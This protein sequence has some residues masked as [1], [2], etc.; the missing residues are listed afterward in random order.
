MTTSETE[1][2]ARVIVET[3]RTA[4]TP[5]I[6]ALGQYH[7]VTTPNG[8]QTID[9]T[10]DAYRQTPARK[11]GTT[12]VADV[13]SFAAYWAK[14]RD[15][16]SDLYA[17]RASRTVTAVLDAHSAEAARWGQHR[18]VLR[19][20]HSEAWNA[21]ISRDNRPMQ[22]E[23][24]AEHLEDNRADIFAPSAAEML[25]I[26][27]SIQG[28]AKA[29]F[30]SGT[31]LANGARKLAYVE[32]VSAT[33]GERGDLI[34]PADFTLRLGVFEGATHG[35]DVLARFRYRINGGKLSLTYKLERPADV[36]A[37]AF[38]GVVAEVGEAC[39]ATVLRG[40]APS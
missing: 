16:G 13:D 23:E 40:T 9:L 3:A 21:W 33:A 1:T 4:T 14:H 8:V 5:H 2:D 20:R 32:S 38:E 6:L 35:D 25:E 34:I 11:I 22:Q 31:I 37:R 24:F 15:D 17:D 7:V 18:L 26:A 12:T 36:V 27:Q 28:T 39:A 30:Q 29:E 10:G 19:L